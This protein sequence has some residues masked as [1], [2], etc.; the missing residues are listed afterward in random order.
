MSC[1]LS[2]ALEEEANGVPIKEIEHVFYA[3]IVDLEQLKRAASKERQEQWELRIPKTPKNAG[4]G[5]VRIRKTVKE[6]AEPEF[7]LTTKVKLGE[8]DGKLEL[9]IPSNEDN[10]NQFRFLSEV[11]MIKDRFAFPVENSELV[12]EIDVYLDPEGKYYPWCKIDLEVKDKDNAIPDF[13]IDL[14]EVIAPEGYGE[15]TVEDREGFVRKLYDDYFI[16]SNQFL[17]ETE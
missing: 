9:A 1:L 6:G 13:P 3:K 5:S 4:T 11:G 2:V 17:N 7:V 14:D 12:W 16:T 10:F 15:N 8:K